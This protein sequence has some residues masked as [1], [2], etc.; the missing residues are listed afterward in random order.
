MEKKIQEDLEILHADC[1]DAFRALPSEE[2]KVSHRE[3]TQ[4]YSVTY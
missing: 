3:P 2:L 1:M 4:S